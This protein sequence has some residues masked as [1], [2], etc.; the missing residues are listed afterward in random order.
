MKSTKNWS[1][2]FS[3]NL[4]LAAMAALVLAFG[5]TVMGCGD[6][7]PDPDPSPTGGTFTVT[8]LGDYNDK[9]LYVDG[10]LSDGRLLYGTKPS[11]GGGML[12]PFSLAPISNGQAELSFIVAN[13]STQ[14]ISVYTGSDQNV[15]LDVTVTTETSYSGSIEFSDSDPNKTLTVSFTNG[16]GTVAW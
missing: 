7:D 6:P 8:G 15:A 12:M 9:Y 2:G 5:M 3:K 10:T 4:L 16:N 14:D 13:P 11:A 1:K